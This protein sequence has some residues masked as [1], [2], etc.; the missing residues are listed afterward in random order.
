MHHRATPEPG[1]ETGA[2]TIESLRSAVAELV[3]QPA[4]A[5]GDDDD[6]IGLGLDSLRIMGLASRWRQAGVRLRFSEMAARPTLGHWWDLVQGAAPAPPAGRPAEALTEELDERAPFELA[7][8]QHAYWIGRDPSQVLGGVSAHFY[9]EFD[10][11]ALDPERLEAAVRALLARHGMLRCRFQDDGRQRVQPE[12]P[13]RGLTVH[14]LRGHDASR[15]ET[16]LAE[17]RRLLSNHQLDVEGGLV[18][19]VQL[20]RLPAG[21]RLHVNIEMVAADARSFQVLLDDLA[22]LYVE[23]G[24][25][26]PAIR[27]SYPRYLAERTRARADAR[28]RARA[29][30]Q[31]RLPELPGGPELPMAV[32]PELIRARRAKRLHRWLSPAERE[33]LAVRSR[34]HGL[35]LS[36]VLMTAFA[37]VVAAWSAQPRFL[38]NLP[39]YDREP[40]HEDVAHLV[41]DFTNLLLLDVDAAG[42]L[43]FTERARRLQAR[44]QRD[45]QH[46]DYSGIDVLRDLTRLRGEPVVAPV[47]FTSALNMGELFRPGVVEAFGSPVWTMSQVPQALLDYQAI[48]RDG[49]I[50]LNWD[51]VEDVFPDGV[52]ETMFDANA[53]LLAWLADPG[54]DWG[55]LPDLLPAEQRAVRSSVNATGAAESGR[56]LHE[57]FFERA[58]RSPERPALLWGEDGELSYGELAERALRAAGWLHS[59]GVRPAQPVAVTLPKGPEQ[60]VAVLGVLAAGGVYVPVGVDQPVQRRGR[61]YRD[62]GVRV[63]VTDAECASGLAWPEGVRVV[64]VEEASGASALESPVGVWEES[65]AYVIYTSGST[66]EPKGV[67]VSH[68]AAVNTVEDVNERYGV[69]EEDRVLAVSGLDFDLSVYDV[70]GLLGAGGALVLPR[71]EE[72]REAR[73]LVE[74]VAGRG[75]TVWNSVPALLEMLLVA[76]GERELAGLRLVMVSG[77]WVGLDL[78]ERLGEGSRFVALGGATEA[79]IWSNAYELRGDEVE[80]KWRSVPYGYPLRNQE[81]RVVDGRG[82]DCPDWVSGELWIGGVGVAAGYRGNA[83]ATARQ[84]VEVDGR[85]W[86]RTGDV[87]RYRPDGRLEFQ[88]RRDQQVKIRGHRIEL[89]EIEAALESHPSVASAVAA[90]YGEVARRIG[91]AVVLA[92]GAGDLALPALTAFL[93]DRLPAHMV[94]DRL[95]LVDAVPLGPNGKVDRRGVARR[96]AAEADELAPFAPPQGAMEELVAR[97]WT[98]LL[99]VPEVGRDQSFF[100]LGG[101][102]LLATRLVARLQAAGVS[103]ASLRGLFATPTVAGY[104]ARL[105]LDPGAAR[106]PALVAAPEERHEPFPLTE[107]QRAYWLGRSDDFALGGVGAQSYWE[108]EGAVDV[109]RLELA[110]NRL[111]E[112][113]EMLRAVLDGEGRQRILAAV[114]HYEIEVVDVAGEAGLAALRE[115]MSRQVLDLGRWP[116]F[117]LRVARQGDR[118]RVCFALDHA[119]LDALSTMIVFSELGLVYEDP[120]AELP[121]VG[122]SFRDYVVSVRPDPG[123]LAAAREHWTREAP[124]LPAGPQLPLRTDPALVRS[125]RFTRRQVTLPSERWQAIVRRARAH[126]LAPSTVLGAAYA[127]VLSAWSGQADLTLTLTLFDRRD[128]HP[129]V[130]RVVGDFTSLLLVPHRAAA[131]DGWLAMARRFQ[132]QVWTGLEHAAV[133]AIEV[134]RDLARR[135]GTG[136]ASFPVVFTSALGV[137]TDAF[138]LDTPFGDFAWGLSQTPQVWLDNQVLERDGALVVNWD[139]VEEL[140]CE[141]ALDAMFAA[142]ARLLE[143]LADPA[144]DWWGRLPELLPAEQRAVRASV[145]ATGAAE[146]GR[147]LH[148]GFFERARRSPERPALLWGEDGELSY[149][150]LAE[151]AL[152]VAGLLAG[153]GVAAGDAVGVTLPK[154]AGQVVAVLGV[155]AAG[156]VYVPVGVDQ[157]VQRRG[158]IY[159]DAGV[160]VVVT[161][162]ECASGLAWPEGV[163]VVAVEEAS[164]AS[165]LESPVGVWEESL[166][167]VIY[168]SGSTGEPKGVM[169]SHRA[170]VNTVEDVNERYGVCEE[171]RVLAVSGLDF[172]LSVYDVFGLLGAG[173]A[174]VLPREEER[175]EAR[176]LVELVAGRGVTVWNSVPALLEMLLVAAG[177]RELAGLRLVMVSGDWVGLDLGERLGE[178]S[179]FVALGGATEAA[180]W[181]NAYELRGDEVEGKW[182]SVPYG[183][184]LRNQEY[185][186]VDGRGRDCPDWVSGELWI[187]GVGVAAGYRGNAEA[188]ARQFVEVDGRRW[189]R[190]GDVGRYRPDGRLEFQGRRDQQVKIR[191]HRIE[192]GEIEA[193]LESHPSVR[194]AVALVVGERALTLVAFVVPAAP[195]APPAELDVHLADRLP[196]HMLPQ[197]IHAIDGLPLT[198][199]G[200]VDR[201]RLAGWDEER[202]A[203]ADED[204]AAV[205]AVERLLAQLWTELLETPSVGRRTSFFALGGDSL[206]ATRL[207]EEVRR[208]FGVETS[209]REFYRAPTVEQLAGRIERLSAVVLEEGV[210]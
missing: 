167:Y 97:A 66:G 59:L 202:S 43:P 15:L 130:Y 63:V 138:R 70:F 112:R 126:D 71:E 10:G 29:Y 145:N 42:V 27:F 52:L 152:R 24:A 58:R 75:V 19:D 141:G 62:A 193:A 30:W 68:R 110:W 108:F 33:A 92:P 77:D 87:G 186:V 163:R 144:S 172:D 48:D 73:R 176:R 81:Y 26:L 20:S 85:R 45:A 199:N 156:G 157:P 201:T 146:S 102:S 132:E 13:W 69:C 194:D 47:V 72:R 94:P 204:S 114:P 140:F 123:A 51:S 64:A 170:A 28:E 98:E 57:G 151:R 65:L 179:R 195:N 82:R 155:L 103:G 9:C 35:T 109:A 105:T 148:E 206:V 166:A 1:P 91:A 12:S 128:V 207:V 192:L 25:A 198:S 137:G 177:E 182:R 41:G 46:A 107:V 124:E 185:R 187:G 200:K 93:A 205:S 32:S 5:I 106:A 115:A 129:D 99:G 154:G 183:Y 169:V 18:F 184:P 100:A 96:L 174:L 86:Y 2:P 136:T 3:G 143:W 17:R 31:E 122:V 22:R 162:A 150:E 178:G 134:M 56:L 153:M 83:E 60:V 8:M 159:R 6:L 89:G 80:G 21:A 39:V 53:R 191:G 37:E 34:E 181:S 133:S 135:S 121:P 88:G 7:V 61:I 173:G 101:D 203:A 131:G 119:I 161:D 139:A 196:A 142:H 54:S 209:L 168:T 118:T 147:L 160:R 67:M 171:D 158:R 50:L 180:I 95:V 44:L 127:E 90:T 84:F 188:T 164:G 49:G 55:S 120:A 197:R 113:H 111:V 16:E 125:P 36:T 104:A 74:L 165:A 208:R 23:P 40:L 76:A 79:A 189:Y 175:R 11:P 78:G 4:A 117:D 38:L 210:I 14:D 190:T 116:L 149:G